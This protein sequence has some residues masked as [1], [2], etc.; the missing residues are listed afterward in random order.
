[1]LRS[2][3][4]GV[5]GLKAHQVKMDVIG[6][7]ISNVNTTGYKSSRVTF[8]EMLSQNIQGAR[9]PQGDMGGLNPQQVGL[10]VG[11]GS[12][13][14]NHTQG[15]L[16]STGVAT[17]LAIEGNGFFVVNN[18]QANLYTRAGSLNLDTAGNLT[19]SVNGYKIQGWMADDGR[20]NT[21]QSITDINIPIGQG[22]PAEA[23]TRMVFAGNLD[24]RTSNGVSRKS[25][26]DVFDSLGNPHTVN[27]DFTRNI[28]T[29]LRA[30]NGD[31]KIKQETYDPRMENFTIDFVD[32]DTD[33]DVQLNGTN[34]TVNA[35]FSG[36]EVPSLTEIREKINSIL[37][38]EDY[39]GT[40]SID[41]ADLQVSDLA[42]ASFELTAPM[43]DGQEIR[44][45]Q[46]SNYPDPKFDKMEVDF[47]HDTTVSSPRARYENGVLTVTANWEEQDTNEILETVNNELSA[48]NFE[49]KLG[50][51]L[52]ELD[53]INQTDPDVFDQLN[54][55]EIRMTAS[56]RWDW[57]VSG[58]SGAIDG[59]ISGNGTLSFDSNGRVVGGAESEIVFDPVEG[60]GATQRIALSFDDRQ[61]SISQKASSY[62]IDGIYADG[63]ESGDLDAFS[64]DSTGTIRGSYS[65]GIN[66]NLGQIAI[67]NFNNPT[68]LSKVGD[69]L[70]AAS[71]NSGIAQIG[72][73]GSGGRGD[74]SGGALEM[75][76]VDLADEFTEMITAQRGFQANSKAITSSDEMLQDLVNLKR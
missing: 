53:L 40:L 25:A 29:N 75:S 66:Q 54:E 76:N 24:S 12:I 4:S 27:L 22:M 19:N 71:Q 9:A 6:N 51:N 7:N 74:I 11:I 55:Q 56:S 48:N 5:S 3:Y 28:G 60:A 32:E 18:G 63:Y 10:G 38:D 50:W 58:I 52:D 31:M 41:I 68:G 15:N 1:M 69:T 30:E 23:T 65:N 73:A 49:G 20:I 35:N 13:D 17:D 57:H 44:V 21:D 67:A 36:D 2:M 70:F 72:A 39:T 47:V 34:I 8:K 37:K 64:I 45:F 16:Q 43:V 26:I 62:T 59:S 61:G 14:V 42:G 33:L 46:D